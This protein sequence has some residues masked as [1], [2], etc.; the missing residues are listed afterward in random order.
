[1]KAMESLGG[2]VATSKQVKD[3]L[4]EH[5]EVLPNMSAAERQ[6]SI[7]GL[8]LWQVCELHSK[9]QCGEDVFAIPAAALPTGV[10]RHK[11]YFTARTKLE[12]LNTICIGPSRATAE[13]AK[14]DYDKMRQFFGRLEQR[15]ADVDV[16]TLAAATSACEVA[17][18]PDEM[19]PVLDKSEVLAMGM[20]VA[21]VCS[22]RKGDVCKKS[23]RVILLLFDV[24]SLDVS[25]DAGLRQDVIG[26]VNAPC[27]SSITRCCSC[28]ALSFC[29]IL[30]VVNGSPTH[31]VR[32][33][34]CAH[35][36]C[37]D[38]SSAPFESMLIAWCVVSCTL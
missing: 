31:P 1:M 27:E 36:L 18:L 15:S 16:L 30:L 34:V 37:S 29:G 25:G 17:S 19:L 4:E 7:R 14:T 32:I 5:P 6:R 33:S 22:E 12:C 3:Y 28:S 13:E 24:S 9:N 11:D 10:R 38:R 8:R 2:K 20:L 26:V 35:M 21:A 23:A